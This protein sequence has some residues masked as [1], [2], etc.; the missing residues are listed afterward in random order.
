MKINCPLLRC[1]Y[2]EATQATYLYRGIYDG[3]V[4]NLPLRND[5]YEQK[6]KIIKKMFGEKR[7][8]D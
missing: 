6:E 7:I 1:L 3:I 5:C 2:C 8:N 4:F